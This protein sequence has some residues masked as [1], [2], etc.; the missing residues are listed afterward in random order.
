[1]LVAF[2][3]AARLGSFTAAAAELDLTQGAVSRQIRALEDQLGLKLFHRKN[4]TI[5]LT[6]AGATYARDIHQ[7]LMRIQSA[8]LSVTTNP[9]AGMLNI[10]ILPTF[11]TRWLMPRLPSFLEENNNITVNFV[12]KTSQFDMLSEDVH[13]AIHFGAPDWPNTEGTFLMKEESVPVAA[14]AFLD[15]FDINRADDLRDKPLLHLASRAED[16]TDWLQLNDSTPADNRS[17]IFE[18]FSTV[19]QAAAAGIGAA[20]LPTFLIKK[21]IE[22]GELT[23]LFDTPLATESAYYLMIP[24]AYKEYAPAIALR[25]WIR[26]EALQDSTL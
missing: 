6:E 22:Q 15:Q 24:L 7:A 8:S 18:Q 10:A 2:N 23:V 1:M 4:R 12:T 19:A 14:P 16:W 5:F 25:N 20:L 11:G 3:S 13:A 26:Q 9:G 17:L 21:E